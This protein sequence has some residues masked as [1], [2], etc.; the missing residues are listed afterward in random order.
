MGGGRTVRQTPGTSYE[1]PADAATGPERLRGLARVEL[2]TRMHGLALRPPLVNAHG[3]LARPP[4]FL[5]TNISDARPGCAAAESPR[6]ARGRLRAPGGPLRS[7][8]D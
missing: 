8:S 2:G 6:Q 5:S 4:F 3:R 1:P 7:L